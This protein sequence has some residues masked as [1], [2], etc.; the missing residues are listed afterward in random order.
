M[1]R[2]FVF[3]LM[4]ATP[5]LAQ[6]FTTIDQ[7]NSQPLDFEL[8]AELDVQGNGG[9]VV[10]DG[11][12]QF[13]N[14]WTGNEQF[15]RIEQLDPENLRDLMD[16]DVA[17]S[18][19]INEQFGL[20]VGSGDRIFRNLL[21]RYEGN[22]EEYNALIEKRRNP[23]DGMEGGQV[24]VGIFAPQVQVNVSNLLTTAASLNPASDY[25]PCHKLSQRSIDDCFLPAVGL[26]F[27]DSTLETSCSGTIVGPHHVLTAAHCVCETPASILVGTGS[28]DISSLYS[29]SALDANVRLPNIVDA[30]LASAIISVVNVVM[31]DE[32]LL[33]NTYCTLGDEANM[34]SFEE[35]DLAIIVTGNLTPFPAEMRAQLV[36]PP[37]IN[38]TF[39]IAGFGPDPSAQIQIKSLK[40]Y[41][42]IELIDREGA[43]LIVAG[44]TGDSCRGDSGSGAYLRLS[45]GTL[46]LFASLSNGRGHCAANSSSRYVS[47]DGP[48]SAWLRNTVPEL[49]EALD[50]ELAQDANMCLGW[51]CNST[52]PKF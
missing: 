28:F 11:F 15:G 27:H 19:T 24:P 20:N 51:R 13:Q 33:R 14:D 35:S 2:I 49:D 16:R 23:R 52:L 25:G 43:M 38:T 41:L 31:F 1:W 37:P 44:P 3:G 47:L 34:A 4:V 48:R 22:Y 10:E 17:I 40:R 46:G 50:V 29:A 36:R 9:F 21:A 32:P 39:E 45:S 26:I 12:T 30:K 8:P 6:Q 42:S 18:E 7:L 5:A